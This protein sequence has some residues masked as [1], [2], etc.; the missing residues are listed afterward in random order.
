MTDPSSINPTEVEI[1]PTLAVQIDRR[2]DTAPDEMSTVMSEAFQTLESYARS[3]GVMFSGPPRAIYTSYDED[4]TEFTLAFPIE[5]ASESARSGEEDPVRIGVLPGGSAI[6][7]THTG[8]YENLS[9]TYDAITDWMKE[10]GILESEADWEKFMPLWEEYV[11]DPSTTEPEKLL[12][13][14]FVPTNESE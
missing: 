5:S 14:I 11:G 8:P 6:R 7:F 10:K 2:S 4:E 3:E 13:F 12:T 9:S 1:E